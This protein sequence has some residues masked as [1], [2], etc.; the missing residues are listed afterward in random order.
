MNLTNFLKQTDTLTSQYS[1]DQLTAFIHDIGRVC[2]EHRREDFL[3][4]L[5]SAG[6]EAEKEA[7]KE[8]VDFDEMYSR[9]R[10]NLKSIDS[11]EITLTGILNEEYDDWY[12]DSGEEYY[13]EDNSGISDM[14]EE[15]CSFV[16]I[17]MDMERYKVDFAAMAE[18]AKRLQ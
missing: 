3:E 8:E 11:Q 12:D 17:C 6:G 13:Y 9:I 15:A 4:M 1:T 16:H 10:D 5:K 18:M 14:L 7:D 2:P